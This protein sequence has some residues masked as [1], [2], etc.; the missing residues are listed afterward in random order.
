L[1]HSKVPVIVARP[2][3]QL[4]IALEAQV[5]QVPLG[6]ARFGEVFG[7]GD[8]NGDRVVPRSVAALLRGDRAPAQDGAP[9]DFVFV[10]DAARACLALA[11][12]VGGTR[13]SHDLTFRSGWELTG[14]A[15]ADA[16]AGQSLPSAECPPNPLGW[17][18][19]GSLA[20]ALAETVAWHRE[21]FGVRAARAA[22][23]QAA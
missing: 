4:R 22:G 2:A 23:R 5:S 11:E 14:R 15:M 18:P 9:R 7:P 10:R 13:E 1:Y 21:S 6:I 12:A 3:H 19:E 20:E 8:R 17:R 16:V